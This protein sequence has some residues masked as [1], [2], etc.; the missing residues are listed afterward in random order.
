LSDAEI[1]ERLRIAREARKITQA[2]AADVIGAAR[3]T[4][5]AIEQGKRRLHV[6]ELQRLAA[7]FKT[8]ANAILRREAVHLDMVPRFRKQLGTSDA[9]V[10]DASRLLNTLVRAEIELEDALGIARRRNYPPE[11]PILP[12]ELRAQAEHSAQELRDWLGLGPGAVRDIVSILDLQIG[13]RVYV[14]RLDSSVAG[15]FAFDETAGACVLLNANHPHERLTQSGAHELAHFIATRHEPEVLLENERFLSR[16]ERFANLFQ[17]CFLTP[18][19]ELR[20]R[21]T[22]ITA[23]QSHLTRRHVILLAHAFGVS[24]EALVRRLEELELARPGTWDWFSAQGG[25]SADDVRQVLGDAHE[26]LSYAALSQGPV[27]HRLALLARE[28]WKNGLYSESQLAQMLEVDLHG[29]RELLD[30][31]EDADNDAYEFVRI[32]R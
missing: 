1:G 12:G 11:R 21:F 26:R 22:Q 4:I 9:A 31:V 27:P 13:V 25:I 24:R 18:G 2:E 3:T 8:S 15:L 10:E 23:G 16:D 14:R 6:D 29:V 17:R 30:D 28:A 19:R 7:A 32:Q 5:V 20:E